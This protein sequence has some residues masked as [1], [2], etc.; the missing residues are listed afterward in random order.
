M[1]FLLLFLS[2]LVQ[3][4]SLHCLL[5]FRCILL[6]YDGGHSKWSVK[7]IDYNYNLVLTHICCWFSGCGWTWHSPPLRSENHA[8]E[9]NR[10]W[11]RFWNGWAL[12]WR[13]AHTWPTRWS[14]VLLFCFWWLVIVA[15]Q[16]WRFYL[17][18]D[19]LWFLLHEVTCNAVLY[20]K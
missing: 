8:K 19:K 15:C 5:F 20:V 14:V 3:V 10:R 18:L 2:L 11:L 6:P 4:S 7:S 16:T 13:E 12:S 9:T 1:V 17:G